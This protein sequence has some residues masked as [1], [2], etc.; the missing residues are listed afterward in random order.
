[1]PPRQWQRTAEEL[2]RRETHKHRQE[3]F[4]KR[5]RSKWKKIREMAEDTDAFVSLAIGFKD[6]RVDSYTAADDRSWLGLY[7]SFV[8]SV[9]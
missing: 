3:K 2:R 4:R 5:S 8:V 9:D 6:G 7:D 1:M